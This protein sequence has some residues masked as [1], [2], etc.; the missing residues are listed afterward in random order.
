MTIYEDERTISRSDLAAWLR[1]LADQLDAE[2]QIFYGAGG[3]LVVA[4]QVRC[5]LEIER[6]DDSEISVEIEFAWSSTEPG[7]AAEKGDEGDEEADDDER[8]G[9][10]DPATASEPAASDPDGDE[11]AAPSS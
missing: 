2:G 6:E 4:D 11:Q 5:E 1:Q 8:T 10:S 9:E 7:P 3:R